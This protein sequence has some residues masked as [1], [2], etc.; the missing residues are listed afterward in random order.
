MDIQRFV[1]DEAARDAAPK[2]L[3]PAKVRR[4]ERSRI[5]PGED[6]LSFIAGLPW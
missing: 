6:V 4:V 3:T 5:L 1:R 2:R